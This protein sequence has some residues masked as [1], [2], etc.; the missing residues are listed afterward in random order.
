MFFET[1]SL[2][3]MSREIGGFADD[4]SAALNVKTMITKIPFFS[5]CKNEY[6]NLG[7][8]FMRT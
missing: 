5:L 3:R 7:H 2:N 4:L 8:I 1:E 6:L